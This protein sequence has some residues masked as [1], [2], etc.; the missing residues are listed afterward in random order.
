MICTYAVVG[1]GRWLSR[2]VQVRASPI[3]HLVT[4]TKVILSLILLYV[5]TL[6]AFIETLDASSATSLTL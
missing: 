2:L 6:A 1:C 5:S 4:E 3:A